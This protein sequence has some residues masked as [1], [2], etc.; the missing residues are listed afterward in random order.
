MDD[1]QAKLA[2]WPRHDT[3]EQ[4][5]DFRNELRA[6]KGIP[7]SLEFP[8]ES[9]NSGIPGNSGSGEREF[10]PLLCL[11]SGPLLARDLAALVKRRPVFVFSNV[12]KAIDE[13]GFPV[14]CVESD[15]FFLVSRSTCR[16]ATEPPATGPYPPRSAQHEQSE[17]ARLPDSPHHKTTACPCYSLEVNNTTNPSNFGFCLPSSI[18]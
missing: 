11:A 7:N 13:F 17:H 16:Q 10:S 3:A 15:L 12:R 14:S 4:L 6:S 1:E 9:G 18:P 8:R 2:N 5:E